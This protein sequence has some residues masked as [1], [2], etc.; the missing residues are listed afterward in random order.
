MDVDQGLVGTSMLVKTFPDDNSFAKFLFS[1]MAAQQAV[2]I[3]GF[4][5][6][7]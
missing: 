5:N 2:R 6:V 4:A 1:N 3:I 7:E